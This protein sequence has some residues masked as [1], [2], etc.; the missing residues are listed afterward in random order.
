VA[1]PRASATL[2]T[3]GRAADGSEVMPYY[4]FALWVELPEERSRQL[5][6]V[7]YSFD[8]TTFKTKTL[9]SK[10]SATGFRVRYQGR[11]CLDQ[12]RI[13]LAL[14]DGAQEELV[15]DS[16]RAIGPPFAAAADPVPVAGD[17]HVLIQHYP[18]SASSAAQIADVARA[19]GVTVE[20]VDELREGRL[21]PQT[22]A[23]I[24]FSE[25]SKRKGL[26][27]QAEIARRLGLFVAVVP[28]EHYG[29]GGSTFKIR[30]NVL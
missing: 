10:D 1:V 11:G 30:L 28:S 18:S 29:A 27:L 15:F 12:V 22:S 14:H 26:E 3:G 4:D 13:S 7:T 5:R 17:F 6:E 2:V 8:H 19:L 9:A 25:P 24:Y 16:C 21:A 20:D 23:I